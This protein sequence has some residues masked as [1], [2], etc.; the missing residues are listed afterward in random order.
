VI[1]EGSHSGHLEAVYVAFLALALLAWTARADAMTGVGLGLASLVKFYPALLIPV[2]LVSTPGSQGAIAQEQND[3]PTRSGFSRLADRVIH[4]RNLVMIAAFSATVLLAYVV[5]WG[6]G[7]NSFWF[8]RGYAE[9]EGFVQGARY[10]LL[11][12]TR[13]LLSISTEAFVIFAA[14]LLIAVA[15]WQLMR[16][17]RNSADVA[18]GAL[19]LIG[20]FLLVT[21]PRYAWYYVWLV[22]FLCFAPRLGWFYL[23]SGSV[24]LYLVWYTPL[25]YPGVPNW[26]GA[27]IYLPTLAWLAWEGI[28]SR[29]SQVNN[30]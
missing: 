15:A 20:T 22:P 21:T 16:V 12:L 19:T 2:F 28:N 25:V 30:K 27:S 3:D 5:Y 4:K 6:E 23:S 17:K 26:L 9:G 10:F 29:R 11:D 24:L 14:V 1:F 8:L 7:V 18:R 13:R